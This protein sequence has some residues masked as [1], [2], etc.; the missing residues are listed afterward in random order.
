MRGPH[1][2]ATSVRRPGA[3]PMAV[4]GILG[5]KARLDRSPARRWRARGHE[6]V[7]AC[8]S[9]HHPLDQVD[10]GDLLG[11]PMLDLQAGVDLQ[12]GEGVASR[13]VQELD[14]AGRA[15]AGRAAE[16]DGGFDQRGAGRRGQVWRRRLLDHLLVS[17]LQRAIAFAERQH[18]AFAVAKDLHLYVTG[19]GHE[20]LEENAAVAETCRGKPRDGGVGRKNRL[21]ALAHAHANAAAAGRRL[22]HDR[23]SDRPRG[24]EG[25]LGVRQQLGSGGQRHAARLGQRARAM[26]EP[27][28]IQVRH[29]RPDEDDRRGLAG[30][31]ERSAL[32]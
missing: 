15:V 18:A 9:A 26:L 21:V 2:N 12:E 27:E 3:G 31:G 24:V 23:V 10:A 5:V 16:S 1:G 11:H 22:Q 20:L 17:P 8:G 32:R 29:G 25:A 28:R 14:R 30:L 6:S 7:V 19:G 13:V 4:S